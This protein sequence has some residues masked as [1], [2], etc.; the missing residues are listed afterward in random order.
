MELSEQEKGVLLSAARNSIEKHFNPGSSIP[1]NRQHY[2]LLKLSCGAFVT[3]KLE[4]SLRG[5]IGYL[6]SKENLYNTICHAADQA[7]FSDPRFYPLTKAEFDKIKIEISVLSFPENII[8]YEEIIP[9]KHGLILEIGY[10]RS[11]LL[12]QVAV[13]N[14]FTREQFLSALCEK[15]GLP[16]NLWQIQKLNIQIFTAVIFSDEEI[17]V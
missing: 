1:D 6:F 5:C 10:I 13:H 15:A 16:A 2:P 17:H 14:N 7:A 4:G 11:I 12:P 3:L 8:N 9:G